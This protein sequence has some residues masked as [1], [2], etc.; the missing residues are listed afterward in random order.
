MEYN[1]LP[2]D[3]YNSLKTVDDY[4]K[5]V[6]EIDNKLNKL[7]D[8]DVQLNY[9]ST[10]DISIALY[11]GTKKIETRVCV[12]QTKTGA[13]IG[14]DRFRVLKSTVDFPQLVKPLKGS[15][16]KKEGFYSTD[17]ATLLALTPTKKVKT[18][19]TLLLERSKCLKVIGTYL[20]GLPKLREKMNWPPGMLYPTYNQCVA[21]TGRLASARPNAQNQTYESK[22][23]FVSRF[24]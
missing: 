7:F 8:S 2:Y 23:F 4:E 18:I 6:A 22:I 21:S 9:G 13:N 5:K 24:E 3:E 12:G 10:D 15:E 20:K 1:G 17:S 11:G 19:I 14:R 16:L